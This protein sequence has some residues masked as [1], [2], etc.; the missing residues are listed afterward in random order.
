M[1]L[2][3]QYTHTSVPTWQHI[4]KYMPCDTAMIVAT[5]VAAAVTI[6]AATV[7]TTVAVLKVA[8]AVTA[9]FVKVTTVTTVV[10][11]VVTTVT[12]VVVAVL[13]VLTSWLNSSH[14]CNGLLRSKVHR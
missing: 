1:V 2:I 14:R 11:A 9:M 13:T 7:V 3:V 5:A 12:T 10:A 4:L 6:M 8:T